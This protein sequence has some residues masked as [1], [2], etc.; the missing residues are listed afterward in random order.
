MEGMIFAAGLG[1]RLRPLTNDRPKALVEL[2][3]KPLLEYVILKMQKAGI[4]RIV[5]NVHHYADL[6]EAFLAKHPFPDCELIVSD[7]RDCLLDTGGGLLKAAK[8]FTPGTSVLIHNVDILSEINLSELIQVHTERNDYATLVVKRGGTGRGLRFNDE[9]I[10][11]GWEDRTTG[12][13]KVVDE[14]F[15]Q[16]TCY[17]FCGVH[18]VSAE[19]LQQINGQGAFSII[20][21]YLSLA[22]K[23]SLR[24]VDYD[25]L[26][27]D[28]GTPEA[29]RKA[30]K[31]VQS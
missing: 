11:K 9:G 13:Q 23:H 8:L 12:E 31:M 28:M 30:E 15:Y 4:R 14:D 16:S 1:T 18:I 2:A 25:G 21:E 3:G 20:D 26:F 10:L 5:V 24:M 27:V 7:E 6:I 17:S 29:I 19:L 22:H